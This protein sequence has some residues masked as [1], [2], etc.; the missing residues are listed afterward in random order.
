[1]AM[2]VVATKDEKVFGTSDVTAQLRESKLL[3]VSTSLEKR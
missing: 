3:C 1:M 2:A